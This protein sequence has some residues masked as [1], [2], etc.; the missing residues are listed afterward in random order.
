MERDEES[1]PRRKRA[2]VRKHASGADAQNRRS[3][4][5]VIFPEKQ[6]STSVPGFLARPWYSPE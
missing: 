3:L 4:D 1:K 2:T 6:R 5:T